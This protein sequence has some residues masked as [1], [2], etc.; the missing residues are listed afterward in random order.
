MK[1]LITGSKGFFGQNAVEYFTARGHTVTAWTEDVR[2]S[3]PNDNY[4]VLIPFACKIGGRKGMDNKA[5]IV[6]GNVEIDRVQFQWAENKVGKIVYPGS[7]SAYPTHLSLQENTPMQEDAIGTGIPSDDIYGLY[8]YFSE[9][10]LAHLSIP[11][12][13]VRPVNVY[14]PGQSLDYPMPSIVQRTK[15]QQCSV[16]GSGKQTRDWIHIHDVMR[17][18]EHLMNAEEEIIVN[19][20]SGKSIS[21][22]ELAKTVYRV[23]HG[24]T[25]P[26]ITDPSQPEGP[27]H[28]V[29]DVTRL[30]Q[31][32]LMPAI[33][34]EEGINSIL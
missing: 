24:I 14:G 34:L 12:S 1:I 15:N 2:S 32:D 25:V 7:S 27:S 29:V 4:D 8:N 19:A 5:L 13:I 22:I 3:L 10:M 28:R 21:F 6:A 26:V 30:K 23:V 17:I 31:L 18:F 9:R 16:W 20:G 33:S 11:V